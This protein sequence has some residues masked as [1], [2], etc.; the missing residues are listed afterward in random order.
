MKAN[1]EI[2]SESEIS[3]EEVEK[4][5]APEWRRMK[6]QV[7]KDEGPEAETLSRL[8]IVAEGPN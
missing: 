7:E 5:K 1:G 4:D 2:T 6:A 8:L 3:E